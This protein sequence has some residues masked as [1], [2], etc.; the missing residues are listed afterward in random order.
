[1]QALSK[2]DVARQVVFQRG[3]SLRL[4]VQDDRSLGA[5]YTKTTE[6]DPDRFLVDVYKARLVPEGSRYALVVERYV[7]EHGSVLG[8]RR[9]CPRGGQKDRPT[10]LARHPGVTSK[11]GS[12][13]GVRLHKAIVARSKGRLFRAS[14]SLF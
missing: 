4:H 11:E 10:T 6:V 7:W 9:V 13:P 8:G 2:Q 3:T 12:V 14:L 1:M 5:V